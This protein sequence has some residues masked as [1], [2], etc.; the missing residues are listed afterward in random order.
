MTQFNVAES[1]NF[2]PACWVPWGRNAF[3][4]YRSIGRMAPFSHE[5]CV[6]SAAQSLEEFDD[7]YMP[8]LVEELKSIV[9]REKRLRRMVRSILTVT[10]EKPMPTRITA[11]KS[12]SHAI[13]E[14]QVCKLC[15]RDCFLSAVHCSGC[16]SAEAEALCS[17]CCIDVHSGSRKRCTGSDGSVTLMTSLSNE[18]LDSIVDRVCNDLQELQQEVK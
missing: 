5:Q 7:E 3:I 10:Q 12:S 18:E 2:A 6:L 11:R 13:K 1:V 8:L 17:M 9:Q 15:K 16:C 4:K 14:N